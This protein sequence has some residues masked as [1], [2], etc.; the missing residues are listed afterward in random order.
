MPKICI[1]IPCYN[2]EDRLPVKEFHTFLTASD[3]VFF[4][5][6]ND[7]SSDRTLEI[8]SDLQH[9]WAE[10]TM[11]LNLPC[12]SGKAEAV[13]RGAL[14]ALHWKDFDYMGYFDADLSTPLSEI[15][16]LLDNISQK[17]AYQIAFGSRVRRMGARVERNAA[18][19]YPSRILATLIGMSLKIPVYDTQCGAKLMKTGIVPDIFK[20]PFI[21]RW[22]FDVEIF[23]RVIRMFGLT[24]SLTVMIEVPLRQ[25][26]DTPGSKIRPTYLLKAPLELLKIHRAYQ[27]GNE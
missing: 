17:E 12:N 20:L 24:A 16:L 8:I 3:S 1:I 10:R 18:R 14:E 25:W 11:V 9:T 13:R 21:S 5:F 27:R 6:V 7:G 23:A 22:L 26:I 4:Y 19:H 15:Q 2:E